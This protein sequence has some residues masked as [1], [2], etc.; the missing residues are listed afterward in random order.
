MTITIITSMKEKPCGS[1][2]L[3]ALAAAN[4]FRPA[5]PGEEARRQYPQSAAELNALPL[6]V[7]F[8]ISPS[9]RSS[10]R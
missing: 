3:A 5:P 4:G 6:V 10:G 2:V 9:A 8:F 1:R 7:V